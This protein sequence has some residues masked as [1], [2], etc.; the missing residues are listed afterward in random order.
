[1]LRCE[2]GK[3]IPVSAF[4]NRFCRFFSALAGCKSTL[5]NNGLV[6]RLGIK[7]IGLAWL[8]MS[9]CQLLAMHRSF[10]IMSGRSEWTVLPNL[11]RKC[12]QPK[13]QLNIYILVLVSNWS[14]LIEVHPCLYSNCIF[15][16]SLVCSSNLPTCTWGLGEMPCTM[17]HASIPA[18]QRTLPSD[19]GWVDG[20]WSTGEMRLTI[21]VKSSLVCSSIFKSGQKCL[22]TS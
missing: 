16:E 12:E 3:S 11:P 13:A 20:I 9:F 18:E 19:S 21:H 14:K 4:R 17:S 8:C 15:G 22:R 10:D 7:S 1:M 2:A 6:R 5:Q